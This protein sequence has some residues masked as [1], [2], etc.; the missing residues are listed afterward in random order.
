MNAAR[1]DVGV[2][3][4]HDLDL[5]F[6]TS[7]NNFECTINKN[8]HCCEA[9]YYLYMDGTEYGGIIDAVKSDTATGD[10]TYS[11]RTWH[12]MLES[13]ILEPDAGQDYLVL[14]GE[15]NTVLAS[16][17]QRVGLRSL[18][19]ASTAASGVTIKAYQ[20]S[21]Y[22]GA[23]SGI[24]KM[25]KSANAKLKFTFADGKVVLSAAPVVDYTQEGLYADTIDFVAKKT[26]GKVNHL[27]C[28]GKGELAER[29]V[30]HLY[31]DADGNISQTQT[32]SGV[33]EYTEIYDYSSVETVE[34]LIKSGTD[35]LKELRQQDSLSVS[36]NN[37]VNEFDIGDIV[38]AYDNATGV[39]VA[40]A[41]TQKIVTISN[42]RASVSYSTGKENTT[43]S[44]GAS[45]GETGQ[46][47]DMSDFLSQAYPVGA[48]YISA[49]PT[50]PATLFG[51][52][53]EQL[54]G[55]FLLGCSPDYACGSTGGAAE[56]ILT[57][58]QIPSH[59]HSFQRAPYFTRE[60][61]GGGVV[62]AE[63]STTAGKLVDATTSK[64]GG[65]KAH[66]NMP[67]YLAVYMWQRT[68]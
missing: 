29:T 28:L 64:V 27:I 2:L 38:G 48:I 21:R 41:I 40:V 54:Q 35:R 17:I 20:M 62:Y 31:A 63:Q 32:F 3:L 53:W 50:S 56:V 10:I 12:G 30:V 67:P 46:Q 57:Q 44:S 51:G 22:I 37:T 16:L 39:S 43:Y 34:E 9:G 11:G 23:Y 65:G 55:R 66:D 45:S 7:E 42:G 58:D 68:A 18:F 36:F 49:V 5:S 26:K 13:K 8:D 6:G 19:A 33:D 4:R 14:N 47:G 24:V 61:S 60:M 15:A 25:L 1:E 52:T 59:K